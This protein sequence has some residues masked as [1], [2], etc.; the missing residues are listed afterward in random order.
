MELN[1]IIHG[2]CLE[3]MKTLP[4][5]CIDLIL[6]DPPYGI[7][8]GK[9]FKSRANKRNGTSAAI[10]KDYG[11]IMWD[12]KIPSKEVFMEM[13]RISK[14]QVIFGGN[15]FTRY[16][17]P[18]SGWIVWDKNNGENDYADCELAWS[19]FSKPLR[20]IKHTWNGMIQE[21]MGNKEYR[22]H[23]TQKP[24]DVMKFCLDLYSKE[25]DIIFDPFAGSCT[26]AIACINLKRNYICVEKEKKYVDIGL[27]RV[28]SM[29]K[30]LF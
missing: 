15:Y 27:Q 1:K 24:L 20:K 28:D 5:K 7:N 11:D 17:P 23:P 22:H 30:S 21:D 9:G 10:S 6:T 18:S 13:F 3:Y 16:L 2:D 26:T 19:S 29:T 12:A 25:N 4:D 14:N 8:V